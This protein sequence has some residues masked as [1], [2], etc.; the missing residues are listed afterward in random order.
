[1]TFNSEPLQRIGTLRPLSHVLSWIREAVSPVAVANADPAAAVGA[2]FAA[3]IVARND[4]PMQM[5][6]LKDGWAVA[7]EGLT[8]ASGYSPAI[9]QGM[10]PWVNAGEPIPRGA[11]A[12]VAVDALAS[13]E[14]RVEVYVQATAGDGVLQPGGD[15]SDGDRLCDEGD[16]VQPVHAAIF[17]QL[18]VNS[19]SVRYPKIKLVSLSA[20]DATIDFICPLIAESIRASGAKA[21]VVYGMNIE[22][23]V[24][25]LDC[26][27]VITV[28]QTGSGNNDSA[29][30]AL[31]RVGAL[32]FHGIGLTPGHTAALGSV[33]GRPVL[34]LPGRLD[35][36]LSVFLAVGNELIE[37]LANTKAAKRGPMLPLTKKVSSTIGLAEVVFVSRTTDGMTPLGSAV[38]ASKS[39]L[40]ADGWV[41]IPEASEGLSAGATAELKEL[42]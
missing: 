13:I 15:V 12:V 4:H 22:Q 3:A 9:L 33:N 21:T 24:S 32:A 31:A 28:G 40:A 18:G 29:V 19:I 1:M 8:D 6:A 42:P 20:P 36:A 23:T 27:A 37:R 11:D 39:L 41:L 10:P 17:R 16:R 26:D 5:T 2:T 34:M 25:E 7:S 30:K 35:A 38:F 14:N